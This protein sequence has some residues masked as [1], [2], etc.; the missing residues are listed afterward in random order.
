[1]FPL[2]LII[3]LKIKIQHFYLIIKILR[4]LKIFNNKKSKQSPKA[5]HC[6]WSFKST[7]PLPFQILD[8]TKYSTANF[9]RYLKN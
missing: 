2:K 3:K 5:K 9:F 7:C 4:I 6:Y 1:M 8:V